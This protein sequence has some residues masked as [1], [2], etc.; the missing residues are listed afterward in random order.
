M[1]PW[2]SFTSALAAE[3][4]GI[5]EIEAERMLRR[6][7]KLGLVKSCGTARYTIRPTVRRHLPGVMDDDAS[8]W[9][10][11]V[12]A[13]LDAYLRLAVHLDYIALPER[14]HL[15]PMHDEVKLR[16]RADHA[17]LSVQQAL[18]RLREELPN[19]LEAVRTAHAMG[20]WVTTWQ[21][22]DALWALQL[23]VGF[24]EVLLPVIGLA[25]EA[26]QRCG[27]ERAESR[28]CFQAAFAHMALGQMRQ[29]EGQLEAALAVAERDGNLLSRASVL[30]GMAQLNLNRYTTN[31]V[32]GLI[33][34][35]LALLE[36]IPE[37]DP[38]HNHTPRARALLI[39]F[40]GLRH[41]LDGEEDEALD[42]YRRALREFGNAKDTYNQAR[43]RMRMALVHRARKQPA[44]AA[45]A[46]DR[47]LGVL[48]IDAPGQIRAD[49]SEQRAA[50]ARELGRADEEIH[51]LETALRDHE[52]DERPAAAM[53][54]RQLIEDRCR[55]Y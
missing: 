28:M 45:E 23:K 19:L 39:Q 50:C 10:S 54:V 44:V 27:N 36:S 7:A 25:I 5:G 6:M 37:D 1:R 12:G 22:V 4:V 17:R 20:E 38:D 14:W 33:D 48:N 55:G 52:A 47:A 40:T 53:K 15:N 21:L 32:Q 31:P 11:V 3:V 2:P 26:A 42:A 46:L 9:D 41:F 34:G 35:A 8:R 29:A 16:A 51:F 43:V 18:A 13:T 49:A 30:E 24:A